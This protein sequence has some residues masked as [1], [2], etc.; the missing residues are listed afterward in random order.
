[1]GREFVRVQPNAHRE[2]LH[3]LDPVAGRVLRRDQREGSAGATVESLDDAVEGD[4]VAIKIG[5]EFNALAGAH[6]LELDFLEIGVYVHLADRND[7]KKRSGRL[8]ALSELHLLGGQS[9]RRP[10]TG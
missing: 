8:D 10:V 4:L 7:V 6:L 9:R 3:D 1:M 2:P 5:N